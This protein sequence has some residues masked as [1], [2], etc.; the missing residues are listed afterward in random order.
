MLKRSNVLAEDP[1]SVPSTTVGSSQVLVPA[2]GDLMP[3]SGLQ[4]YLD[5]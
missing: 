3:S 4:G 5:S 1:A 2:P